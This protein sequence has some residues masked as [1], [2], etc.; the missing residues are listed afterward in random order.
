MTN[1]HRRRRSVVLGCTHPVVTTT[2]VAATVITAHPPPLSLPLPLSPISQNQF[3]TARRLM[4]GVHQCLMP[5][6]RRCTTHGP[7]RAPC[8]AC[9]RWRGL[10][11]GDPRGSHRSFTRDLTCREPRV[12]CCCRGNGRASWLGFSRACHDA[13]QVVTP[14]AAPIDWSI[15]APK[16]RV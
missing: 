5:A 11:G 10:R 4:P 16:N 9:P 7:C 8:G 6:L 15:G 13:S 12:R 3:S 2:T 1:H 14:D